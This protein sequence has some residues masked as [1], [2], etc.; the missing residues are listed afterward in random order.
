MAIAMRLHFEDASKLDEEFRFGDDSRM[1]IR[2]FSTLLLA[3][4]L[5]TSLSAQTPAKRPIAIDDYYRMQQVGNPQTS[6]DGKWIAYT[7]TTIDREA[8]KRRT[9]IWMVNWEGTQDLRLSYGQ[10]SDSSPR[11]S[12]DGKYLAFLSARTGE[13]K[14]QIWL[15]DR[16]GGDAQPLTSV[17]DEIS[18]YAWSPDGKK[19]VLEMSPSEDEENGGT[20]A[21]A[22]GAAPKAPKPIVIDR[23]HFKEDVEGYV[24]AASNTQLY[25]FDVETKKL[26]PLTTE[27]QFN[28]SGPVW[29]PDGTQI[30]FVSNHAKDPDQ[31]GTNDIF[32]VE[33]HA[34]ATSR[35]VITAYAPNGQHLSWSPDGKLIAY[36]VGFEPKY[37]SYNQDL[38]AVVPAAGGA[39]RILTEKLDRGVSAPA[40]TSDGSSITFLVADDRREYPAKIALSGGAVEKLSGVEFV[41]SQQSSASGHSAVT[42]SN[43][44]VAPEIFAL[45]AGKLRKLTAHNDALLAEIQLG[46]VEDISFKSKDGTEVHGIMT[47][48]ASYDSSK[49]YPTL[50]WIHGG[51]NG[52]DDHGLP[53]NTYPLQV[54]RQI[55]A[56]HGYVVLA[57]NYRG[58]KLPICSPV[59]T[60][61]LRKESQTRSGSASAA[62]VTA[63]C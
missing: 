46:A 41:V 19:I 61:P 15:L 16:R 24:T 33:A 29:S 26:E 57:I 49:K 21:K 4:S 7:V 9:A 1:R 34:G 43:D 45:E 14:R 39:S 48:P 36:L 12:P 17:K 42:A 40:F 2:S 53:F 6:P 20:D 38:L 51:P 62:G 11:W 30:A 31:S 13:G 37:S 10:Q 22:S 44:T 23:Y 35:K 47:K 50:L 54:E 60:T 56:T 55:F 3:F 27:K 59:W 63:G 8:D 52:Q 18:S 32:V 5:A 25:L 58:S 28:D